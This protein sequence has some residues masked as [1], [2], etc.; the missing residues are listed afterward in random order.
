MSTLPTDRYPTTETI[1]C[2]VCPEKHEYSRTNGDP[3]TCPNCKR[4]EDMEN[5]NR[6][7]KGNA[8]A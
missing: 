8:N 3:P 1:T 5:L 2:D 6:V 4:L 7:L